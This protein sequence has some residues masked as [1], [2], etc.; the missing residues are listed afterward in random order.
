MAG[1]AST[2]LEQSRAAKFLPLPDHPLH[3]TRSRHSSR[4]IKKL[5]ARDP[6]LCSGPEGCAAGSPSSLRSPSKRE[7]R[8]ASR[9]TRSH[10]A[11]AKVF[12]AADQV[13]AASGPVGVLDADGGIVGT[14]TRDAVIAALLDR[15]ADCAAVSLRNRGPSN[16]S[17]KRPCDDVDHGVAS[18]KSDPVPR[19]GRLDDQSSAWNEVLGG[20]KFVARYYRAWWRIMCRSSERTS[21]IS[22]RLMTRYSAPAMAKTSKTA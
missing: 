17:S 7:H 10:L 20:R 12:D 13:L 1:Y 5:L 19:T 6:P 21:V 14:V 22:T 11:S 16:P 2:G 15:P 9:R 3:G 4:S 8:K 18:P